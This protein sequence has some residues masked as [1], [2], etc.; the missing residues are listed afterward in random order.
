LAEIQYDYNERPGISN[1]LDMLK[2]LG[3]NPDEFRGQNQYGP[4]KTEVANRV[5]DFLTDFQARLAAVDENEIVRKL[6]GSELLMDKVGGQRL[7]KLQ[8]AVGLRP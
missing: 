7:F 4:L 6:E 8:Q 3:G 1:L 2:L 5:V